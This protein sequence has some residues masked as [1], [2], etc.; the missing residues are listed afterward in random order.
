MRAVAFTVDVDRDVNEV[1]KGQTCSVSH[2]GN[3]ARFD[4]SGRGLELIVEALRETGVKGTF[5][6]EGRTAEVL[7]ERMDVAGMMSGHEVAVHGYDHEDLSGQEDGVK[8][9]RQRVKEIL[10]HADLALDRT[11]GR[12]ERG[13]RAPYQRTS[14]PLFEEL[15]DRGALYDSSET[16]R[17][18]DGK[19]G[20][21]RNEQG[22]L[23]AP[24]CWSL[25]RRGKKI[26]SYLWPFHEGKRNIS[27]YLDL[28]DGFEDGLLVIATHS[29]HLV[30]NYCEGRLSEDKVTK[31]VKDLVGFL[32]EV[33]GSGAEMVGI[34]DHLRRTD[35][36]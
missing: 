19:V 9:D 4:S 1:C 14:V 16:V 21:Y 33:R 17:M 29:W 13:F 6:W 3:G 8:M 11:F 36:L 22:V 20:P 2:G 15:A 26:V 12:I 5:F 34:S 23:E 30:E 10:D 28:V 18:M 35:A 27:D 31:R 25:D 32:E 7:A 24:V